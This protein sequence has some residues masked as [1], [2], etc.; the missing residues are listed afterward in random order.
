MS[1]ASDTVDT[2]DPVDDV[3]ETRVDDDEFSHSAT[4]CVPSTCSSETS[5]APRRRKR[6]K[7]KGGCKRVS[8]KIRSLE[9]ELKGAVGDEKTRLASELAHARYMRGGNKNKRKNKK[10]KARLHVG[11]FYKDLPVKAPP[12]TPPMSGAASGSDGRM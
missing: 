9:L 11:K 3:N 1:L 2:V 4:T 12:P 10:M 5:L 8:D 6:K 7:K